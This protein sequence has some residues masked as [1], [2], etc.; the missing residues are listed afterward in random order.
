MKSG[1]GVI[2]GLSQRWVGG[3]LLIKTKTVLCFNELSS[4]IKSFYYSLYWPCP[5]WR[6]LGKP[7]D[8]EEKGMAKGSH[9]GGE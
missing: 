7:N 5:I 9:Q 2:K 8:G 6:A 1:Q 3:M 4:L